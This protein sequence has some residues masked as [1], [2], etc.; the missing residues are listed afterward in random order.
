MNRR[1]LNKHGKSK[2]N[3]KISVLNKDDIDVEMKS[4]VKV[5]ESSN[6]SWMWRIIGWVG[7]KFGQ[8]IKWILSYPKRFIKWLLAMILMW[9]LSFLP[10]K[11]PNLPFLPIPVSQSK[12]QE[13][14][15]E[16]KKEDPKK[17][18]LTPTDQTKTNIVTTTV[19]N[20]V[21]QTNMVT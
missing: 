11:L 17:E 20:T 2:N 13:N 1:L 6:K 8:F 14:K 19:T 5:E 10:F 9:L 21:T 7:L 3:V 18:Q 12:P 16:E 4:T 15:K